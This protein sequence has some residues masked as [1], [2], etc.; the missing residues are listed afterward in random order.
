MRYDICDSQS[1]TSKILLLVS[2]IKII[3]HDNLG[4]PKLLCN[5]HWERFGHEQV[6]I[7]MR[8]HVPTEPGRKDS[9]RKHTKKATQ[10]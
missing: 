6:E 5:S 4:E 7:P 1:N 3:N 2:G 10:E 8:V 9:Q